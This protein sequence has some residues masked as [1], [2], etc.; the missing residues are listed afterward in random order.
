MNLVY[1]HMSNIS[2]KEFENH[3]ICIGPRQFEQLLKE[4]PSALP[5]FES[6]KALFEWFCAKI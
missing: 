6:E 2:A 3:A 4:K 5:A 1:I